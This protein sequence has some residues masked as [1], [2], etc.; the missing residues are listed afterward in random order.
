MPITRQGSAE[1]GL[2]RQRRALLIAATALAAVAGAAVIS[3]GDPD[4]ASDGQADS[5]TEAAAT[6]GPSGGFEPEQLGE[7]ESRA[8]RQ[9]EAP[10]PRDEA[11]TAPPSAPPTHA[12]SDAAA[13]PVVGAV[14]LDDGAA[15]GPA[16]SAVEPTPDTVA[17]PVSASAGSAEEPDWEELSRSIV[18]LTSWRC[19]NAGSGT[20]I[21]DGTYVLT[22]SHVA[23]SAGGANCDLLI[24]LTDRSSRA[25]EEHLASRLVAHD[26]HLDMA[27]LR[28]LDQRGNPLTDAP[29][30]PIEMHT[31]TLNLGE[32]IVTLGYPDVGG[33]T[34]T[35]TSGDYSGQVDSATSRFW[36]TSA[37]MGPGISGGAAFDSMGRFIG[38]PTAGVGASLWC[39]GITQSDCTVSG[40]SLGLILPAETVA[41]WLEASGYGDLFA[42][43]AG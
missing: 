42:E 10:E 5:P 41:R 22:N 17:A 31:R 21:G 35:I 43:R 33:G 13:E 14:G 20:I 28:M 32:E 8:A 1:H 9:P 39:E 40:A 36:K 19:E 38:I 15:A 18:S 29:R 30:D 34:I 3:N 27:L 6:S 23:V 12:E 25:P 16:D 24:W 26:P 2:R 4:D 11:A 7:R 37:A